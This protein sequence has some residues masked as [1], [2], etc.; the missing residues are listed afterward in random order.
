SWNTLAVTDG[1]TG[2]ISYTVGDIIY[3][4]GTTSMA[5]LAIG[6]SNRVL[7]GGSSAPSYSAVSLTA[8]VSGILPIAN[9]GTNAS[10][11]GAAKQVAYSDGSKYVFS[12][13]PS[14]NNVL[15]STGG[16]PTFQT[17]VTNA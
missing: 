7:H 2:I 6:A 17:L 1:A 5:K 14:A 15:L 3:A 9:G 16:N 13:T 4:N 12:N 11:L 8:D 10:V